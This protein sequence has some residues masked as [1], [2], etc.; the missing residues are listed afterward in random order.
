ML[1]LVKKNDVFSI[2]LYFLTDIAVK[3]DDTADFFILQ[4]FKVYLYY[5]VIIV[6]ILPEFILYLGEKNRLPAAS[7]SGKHLYQIRI[8]KRPDLLKVSFAFNKHI[9]VYLP[10]WISDNLIKKIISI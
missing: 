10:G 9:F 2:I 5:V 7:Y 6:T 1:D 3:P 4:I 8:I